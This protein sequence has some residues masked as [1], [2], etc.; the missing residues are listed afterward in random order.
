MMSTVRIK[1][2]W[3]EQRT[4]YARAFVATAAIGVLAVLLAL[5]LIWLQVVRHDYYVEL[6]QGNRVRLDPI[7]ASRGLILD[8]NGIVLVDN[9]PA[10]QLELIREQTPDL[11]DTLRR[12][13]ALGLIPADEIDDARRMVLSRRSFDSVPIRL[14]L[15]DE[16]IGRFA[17][18]RYE[19]PG[20]DL[21]TRQTR[22]YPYGEL[23]VH[24][25]GYV[26]A[27]SEQDL[28]RIDRA[29]YAGTSLIGKLGVESAY[30]PQLHGRN[31]YRE[32]LVNAQG[33]SVERQGAYQPELH[34]SPPLAG[35]DL[36]LSID[37]PAQEAAETGLGEHRGAVVAIDPNNGDV[38]A[39]ASH[40]GFDPALFG[41]GLTRAEYAQLTED[42]DKPLLN[43]AL[44]GAYPSGSTIKPVIALAGLTFKVV[45]PQRREFCNGVFHLP[46]S[47]HL[48]REG[49]GGRHGSVDLKDAI[50]RSCDVYFY[51]LAAALG[52][53][54]IADFMGRFGFGAETGIDIGGEKPGILPSPEWKKKVFRRPQDQVWFPGE[55]VNFG[56]G[57]GYL[58]VTPLQ[59]AHAAA[60]LAMR[61]RSFRP[62]L[63]T[64][65]RDA[66]TGAVRRLPPIP[67][68][69]VDGISAAD[70]DVVIEGMK[71]AATYGTAAA[72]SRGAPYTIAGKTGT[73]QVFSIAQNE[74]Y[75]DALNAA[76]QRNER[77]RDHSW[78][79]AFA[80]A[81]APRIAVC[82][83]VE[84]G[85]F[86]ASVAAPIARRV[87]DAYLLNRKPGATP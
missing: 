42:I 4:F 78:F 63:V 61:G 43:R 58:T 30:E 35:S 16:E 26:G 39:L 54:H 45:E 31:G 75:N 1:D 65:V 56:V 22:H 21:R 44:R 36:I 38:I 62:R 29:S 76:R 52:V 49:K 8:R 50:A 23:G 33:R 2:H 24:A 48:Y 34:S 66:Y 20:V 71:G 41:R 47:A 77:L 46:R 80:P 60:M 57:Q 70:W 59:L 14:R 19:F 12:L 6:S 84:N 10:Y 9:E 55:T 17:V 83:L 3:N 37:L 86:G 81:E 32:I 68:P 87:M 18:H 73:A 13:A 79:I 51:G 40:P 53:D 85:G 28:E 11:D 74:R 72:I 5:R 69:G 67:L 7:P 27:I 82:V 25:L 15:T 64:G